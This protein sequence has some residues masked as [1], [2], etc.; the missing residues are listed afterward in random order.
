MHLGMTARKQ[1][2]ATV[3]L[4]SYK[5]VCHAK[6]VLDR[7]LTLLGSGSTTATYNVDSCLAEVE[8]LLSYCNDIL[9]TGDRQTC[10]TYCNAKEQH[11]MQ[12]C[13]PGGHTACATGQQLPAHW[14]A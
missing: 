6:Q 10:S 12:P 4:D 14:M 13:R 1:T 3:R 2:Q 7:L 11:G 8:D 5:G 9:S